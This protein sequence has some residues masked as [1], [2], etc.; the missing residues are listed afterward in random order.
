MIVIDAAAVHNTLNFPELISELRDAFSK[1][2]GMPQRQ[3]FNLDE[4]NSHSDAFA[5]LPSWNN[6]TI[7][8][9]AFTYFP[10]N[11]MENPELE[12]LYSKI[13]IFDR[14]TGVPQAL[15]DGT[16]ITYWRTAAISALG[17]DFLAKKDA[18]TLLVCGTGRLSSYMA[19][20]HAGVRPITKIYIWGRDIEKA[21]KTVE[22]IKKV[23]S[24]ILVTVCQ[25]LKEI[26]PIADIISCAT[27]SA[28]PLFNSDWVKPGTHTDF[29]GNHNHDRRECDSQLILKSAVYV[30]SKINVFA[31]A[32]EILI[33]I[34]EGLYKLDSVKGELAQLCK[35]EITGRTDDQEITVF[36][37]VGTALADLVGAQLVYS[38]IQLTL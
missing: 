23:R 5:I 38:R 11:P 36:K 14:K 2:A 29:V 33:P 1:P 7:A 37:T 10:E 8:V 35:G 6:K 17:S 27:G 12:S 26:V 9:K 24:D 13:M 3:V 19:L 30:D 28:E 18:R 31:E 4:A 15:V 16:S 34:S 32:G 20:A 22:K 21:K 25:S